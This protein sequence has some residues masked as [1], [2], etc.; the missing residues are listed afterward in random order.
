MQ[1]ALA[2]LDIDMRLQSLDLDIDS[3]F[4]TGQATQYQ[5]NVSATGHACFSQRAARISHAL[6]YRGFHLRSCECLAT[7]YGTCLAPFSRTMDYDSLPLPGLDSTRSYDGPGKLLILLLTKQVRD[8]PHSE[9]SWNYCYLLTQFLLLLE[10]VYSIYS[11]ARYP[12]TIA[13]Y[14][15]N[16]FRAK[17]L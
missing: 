12:C 4:L 1:S 14:S 17:H 16:L 3:F 7:S 11:S 10:F 9:I 6:T 15:F 8:W 2:L 13:E 5:I